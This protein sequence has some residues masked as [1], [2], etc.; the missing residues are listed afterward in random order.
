M[1]NIHNYDN[2]KLKSANLMFN[3]YVYKK[4]VLNAFNQLS[5]WLS[6]QLSI[7]FIIGIPITLFLWSIKK[8]NKA[9]NKLLSI[10]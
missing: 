8:G 7:I 2:S 6:F 9:V 4:K 3:D 10:Y 5:V 1:H